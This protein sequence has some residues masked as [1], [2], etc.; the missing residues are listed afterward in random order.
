M[1]RPADRVS[2]ALVFRLPLLIDLAHRRHPL[3]DLGESLFVGAPVA[4][5]APIARRFG[6]VGHTRALLTLRMLT[7]EV[8][9]FVCVP[10]L[11]DVLISSTLRA[12]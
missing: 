8:D 10:G 12:P 1:R 11:S 3:Y 4:V 7:G 9:E 5:A 2:R 6:D